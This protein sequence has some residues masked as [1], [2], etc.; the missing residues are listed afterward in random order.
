MSKKQ[1]LPLCRRHARCPSC[2]YGT[3]EQ[4]RAAK[5]AS[6]RA[7]AAT[8]AAQRNVAQKARRLA[9]RELA[10][11]DSDCDDDTGEAQR[12]ECA[13]GP[14]PLQHTASPPEQPDPAPAADSQLMADATAPAPV[15]LQNHSLSA[16]YAACTTDFA[17]LTHTQ[18]GSGSFIAEPSVAGM[19]AGLSPQQQQQIMMVLAQLQAHALPAPHMLAPQ[20]AVLPPPMPAPVVPS[21]SAAV[22]RSLPSA[23]DP[24]W[25]PPEVRHVDLVLAFVSNAVAGAAV[26]MP[27]SL[28]CTV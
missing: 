18:A 7:R 17:A 20:A 21:S 8:Q 10:M 3:L 14:A 27:L 9:A 11:H 6:D 1:V 4:R 19:L 2:E 25:V 5:A 28:R 12:D 26:H 13:P 23:D 24:A 22:P 16:P 15:A